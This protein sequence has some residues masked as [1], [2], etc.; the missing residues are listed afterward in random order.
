[1]LLPANAAGLQKDSV[2]NA[3]QIIAVDRVFLT[4]RVAKLPP[5]HFAQVMSGIDVV[6][7]R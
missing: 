1:V 2:A 7:G 4:E 5:K 6:L 3:S